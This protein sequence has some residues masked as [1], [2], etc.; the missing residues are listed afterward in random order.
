MIAGLVILVIIFSLLLI[1]SADA[2]VIA[3]RRIAKETH[4][5]VFVVSSVI[6]A[7]STS[8]PELFV[9]ITSAL[10]K[11]SG[12]AVGVVLGSN[13]ANIALIGALAAIIVGRVNIRT[14]YIQR[15]VLIAFIAGL[16]PFAL[17]LF[18]RNLSRVDGLILLM[19]YLAYAAGFFRHRYEQIGREHKEESF[20]YRFF[21]KVKNIES[22][23]TKELGRLFL[24]MAIMLFSADMIVKL[25]KSLALQ[26]NID[27]FVIG[28][29]VLAIGTS[30]PE[31]AFSLRSLEDGQPTMFLGNIL[32]SVIANSTLIV[33]ITVLI[34]PLNQIVFSEYLIAVLIFIASFLVFWFFIKTKHTL[35]RW[36]AG[37]LLL[38]YLIFLVVEFV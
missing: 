25:S 6:L 7:V 29:I 5:G 24:G 33:G 23:K 22:I 13:I 30:L 10:E 34:N 16:M 9:G 36:E 31:F 32:G 15:D 19:V 2:V 8:F 28:L 4:A 37:M 12:L 14:D 26:A 35:V 21:K 27:V 1:K 11:E 38:L 17:L 3:I 18:D 20:V